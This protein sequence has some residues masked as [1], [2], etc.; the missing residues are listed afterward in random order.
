MADIDWDEDDWESVWTEGRFDL[1]K[2]DG[3]D[4]LINDDCDKH[5]DDNHDDC[6]DNILCNI[7]IIDLENL[8]FPFSI[9][10]TWS[11]F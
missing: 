7:S 4:D 11:L 1:N 2:G 10:W 9:R 3:C 6:C 8:M 5:D